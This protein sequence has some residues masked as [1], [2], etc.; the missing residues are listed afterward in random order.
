MFDEVEIRKEC[1]KYKFKYKIINENTVRIKSAIDAWYV[2][3]IGGIKP[4]LLMHCN[5]GGR[6]NYEHRQRKFYD[7]PFLLQSI[8]QHDQYK[9]NNSYKKMWRIKELYESL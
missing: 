2:K 7:M 4:Y 3:D 9:I 5:K 8:Y 1:A 6:K